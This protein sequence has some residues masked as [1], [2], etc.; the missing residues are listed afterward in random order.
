MSQKRECRFFESNDYLANCI[1]EKDILLDRDSTTF[2]F[3]SISRGLYQK[4]HVVLSR[5]VSISRSLLRTRKRNVINREKCIYHGL[6]P[7]R[8]THKSV[9]IIAGFMAKSINGVA[10]H[11]PCNLKEPVN[12]SHPVFVGVATINALLQILGLFCRISSLL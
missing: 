3:V 8:M 11:R 9:S 1:V 2:L 4:K 7:K 6:Y 5:T 12:R 10:G